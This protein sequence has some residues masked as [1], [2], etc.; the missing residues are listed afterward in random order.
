MIAMTS[1]FETIAKHWNEARERV[2]LHLTPSERQRQLKR[3]DDLRSRKLER[4]IGE[5]RVWVIG[6]GIGLTMSMGVPSA[7]STKPL[8]VLTALA[9][10]AFGFYKRYFPTEPP[11]E[12]LPSK[13]QTPRAGGGTQPLEDEAAAAGISGGR[14]DRSIR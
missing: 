9:F 10:M 7:V 6:G 3:E 4:A 8:I 5:W 14:K 2:K 13:P 11:P 1:I 12:E